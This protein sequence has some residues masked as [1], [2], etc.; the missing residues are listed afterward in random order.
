ME[1]LIIAGQTTS[2]CVRASVV[3][4]F[5]LGFDVA[6]VEEA[7]F[8]RSPLSHKVNMF[9]MHCKYATAVTPAQAT[10]LLAEPGRAELPF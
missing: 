7:T 5:S 4:A 10:E 8:D 9:D 1:A 6:V 3:D 2:G